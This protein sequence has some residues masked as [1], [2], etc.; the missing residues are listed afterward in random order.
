[1]WPWLTGR[2]DLPEPV[3]TESLQR[4]SRYGVGVLLAVAVL[5]FVT[6]FF[7]PA[8]ANGD[9]Y[10]VFLLVNTPL[11]LIGA[12]LFYSVSREPGGLAASERRVQVGL[13]V[14]AP[15]VV[16]G[17]WLVGGPTAGLNLLFAVVFVGFVRLYLTR[18]L[19]LVVLAAIVVSD[20]VLG[21]ARLSGA[22]GVITALPAPELNLGP[23]VAAMAIGWRAALLCVMFVAAGHAADRFRSS[24]QALRVLNAE[25]ETRVQQQVNA[26][27]RAARLRRYLA[28]QVVEEILSA[29]HDPVEARD[30]RPIT[31]MFADMRGFTGMVERLAPDALAD[32]LNLYFDEVARVAFRHGGTI[33]KFIGDAVMVFFGAPRATGAVDQAER[34]VRMALDVQARVTEL[35][36]A[37]ETLTGYPAAVR[38]GIASGVATVGAFGS[39]HRT[40][41]TVVGAPVNRAARIEPLAPIGTVLVDE[42]TRGLLGTQFVCERLEDVTL[43]GFTRP[44]S[45]YLAQAAAQG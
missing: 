45:V 42:A 1:V 6:R 21:A 13:A 12:A 37:F 23:S 8:G 28:P 34:C 32:T 41:F 2:K 44:E 31:V 17:S 29:D 4:G 43:K 15:T 3:S 14:T 25:L 9:V 24:E 11:Q 40:D 39:S 7:L 26:L 16:V 35:A 20:L 22:F 10:S 5:N 30:R 19:G 18:R 27:E 33:D 36:P 38:I